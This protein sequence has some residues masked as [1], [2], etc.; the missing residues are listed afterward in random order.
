M[1]FTSVTQLPEGQPS[2]RI[3]LTGQLILQ[4]NAESTACEVFVNR[5][6]PN[7][8]L[9]I[10][11]REKFDG[12]PDFILM[13][14]HGPLEFLH[15]E[16]PVE[17]LEIRRLTSATTSAAGS[18]GVSAYAGEPT[19][20][21]EKMSAIDLSKSDFHGGKDLTI[22]FECARPS[23]LI[24]DGIFNTAAQTATNLEFSV[25]KGTRA[26]SRKIP[27]FA[28][29]V[30]ANIY[31]GKNDKLS[32]N[33]TEMGLPRNLTL[34]QP[35]E[36]LSYEIYIINDPLYDDV[37]EAK[38]HDEFAEYYKVLTNVPTTER[39]KMEMTVLDVE[40]ERGS[41]KTPCMPVV[42]GGD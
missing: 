28:S 37:L 18:A 5:S 25:K 24:R 38:M 4:P 40:P 26:T 23:I 19:P 6:A 12:E 33:W 42:V 1:P 34:S 9:T 41:A 39:L 21:G 36:G 3:F 27:G 15:S 11:V 10:E 29:I 20:Y 30:G 8:H 22:D 14:H 13:R 31:L 17:G 32:L 35:E 7:H 2:V 16:N